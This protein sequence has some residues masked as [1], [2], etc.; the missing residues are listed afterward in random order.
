MRYLT[1]AL[2]AL[3]ASAAAADELSDAVVDL[4]SCSATI[5]VKGRENAYGVSAAHCSSAVG[6]EF[7]FTTKNGGTGNARWIAIDRAHDLALFT[8]WSKDIQSAVPVITP[9]PD[10]PEWSAVGFPARHRGQIV[11]G[12]SFAGTRDITESGSNRTILDRNAFR[13]NS[14]VL[15]GGE[16]GGAVFAVREA[17]GVSGLVGVISHGKDS[18]TMQA[19]TNRALVS[20]LKANESKMVPDCRNGYCERWD[21]APP[22]PAERDWSKGS[23]DL[24]EFMDSDRERGLLI[25]ELMKQLDE[26]RKSNAELREL[27]MNATGRPGPPGPRGADGVG[28]P[29]PPGADGRAAPPVDLNELVRAV[30]AK[31][32]DQKQ[33]NLD[34]LAEEVKRRLPP[35]PASF[36]IKPL[37]RENTNGRK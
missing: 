34:V 29:G 27:V 11:Q 18:R 33:L 17:A 22:P 8:C 21:V 19:S 15:R 25:Q 24:P 23:H 7:G 4:P 31:M 6:D 36:Q 14:W 20:F 13:L 12:A 26:L 10:N 3:T 1:L 2:V 9:L 5:I 28:I 16:S 32:P 35:I 37:K 30:Q